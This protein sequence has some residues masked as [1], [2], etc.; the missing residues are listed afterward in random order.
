[1]GPSAKTD[2][3]PSRPRRTTPCAFPSRR[4]Y[5][6]SGGR[7]NESVRSGNGET[8]RHT[9]HAYVRDLRRARRD[10]LGRPSSHASRQPGECRIRSEGFEAASRSLAA[11][12]ALRRRG[13]HPL[14][15]WE[16]MAA[17]T[18]AAPSRG[19]EGDPVRRPPLAQALN[20]AERH[21]AQG[22]ASSRSLGMTRISGRRSSPGSAVSKP[23]G[24]AGRRSR[25]VLDRVLP[26]PV[27][28]ACVLSG[29]CRHSAACGFT[30][31]LKHKGGVAERVDLATL[32][33][34]HRGAP[35]APPMAVN[36]SSSRTYLS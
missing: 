1:M 19:T 32:E 29:D 16:D 27:P 7:S 11:E 28:Q 26:Q 4:T 24:T 8:R 23:P 30:Y 36:L 25:T 13:L 12:P 22:S 9:T 34:R 18:R 31:N 14:S 20:G 33:L 17:P 10:G 3:V 6:T 35:A 15:A 2:W 21:V 5:R